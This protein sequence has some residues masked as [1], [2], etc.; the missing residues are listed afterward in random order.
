M[1]DGLIVPCPKCGAK[2]R[3]NPAR[4][5]EAV[6]GK[7]KTPIMDGK[8]LAVDAAGF[9]THVLQSA[10]PVVVDFWA[11]WCS[12][13]R[14]MAPAFEQAA[15][16]LRS[17]RFVKLDTQAEPALA[18]RNGIQSIPTMALFRGGRETARVSGAMNAVQIVSWVRQNLS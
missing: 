1:S 13:C 8:P 18:S 6:C 2:N 14:M 15:A 10:V 11:P 9:E 3:I 16:D 4:L 12:P 7:C 5:D 17:V